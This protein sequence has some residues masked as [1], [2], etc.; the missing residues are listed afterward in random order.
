MSWTKAS[1]NDVKRAALCVDVVGADADLKKE[2][3]DY[4]GCCT[5][6][7]HKD[8]TPSLRV[9]VKKNVWRCHGCGAGGSSVDWLMQMHG[10]QFREAVQKLSDMTGT[11]LVEEEGSRGLRRKVAEYRYCD[12]AGVMLYTIERWEPGK[13]GRGKDFLQ[14]RADGVY[15]KHET[16]VLYR[17]PDVLA[18]VAI[19]QPVFVVEGEKAAEALW[20]I[21]LERAHV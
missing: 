2:G 21:G 9:S 12:A 16:Q 6:P 13:L 14:K 8:D 5:L 18:A 20:A 7:G 19:G 11:P 1:I 17:L 3:D 15:K 4:V 10:C